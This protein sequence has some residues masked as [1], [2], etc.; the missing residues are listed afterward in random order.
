MLQAHVV[1]LRGTCNRLQ[2][3][4]V[5]TLESRPI[6]VGYNGSPP[7][8][9]HCGSECNPQD[10]CRNTI[11]AEH[12]ALLWALRHLGEVPDSCTLYVTDSPCILCAN[13]IVAY[14]VKRVV[15]DRS[16]RVADGLEYLIANG[17]EVVQCHV[18]LAA[19][20]N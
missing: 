15:Y 3:G 2:V 9:P 1:A 19:S 14:G 20:A 13:K 5:L 10:P 8:H 4:A 11:H 17:V 7:G 6:S 16:Y 18:S 12:N